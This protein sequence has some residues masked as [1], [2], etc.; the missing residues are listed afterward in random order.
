MPPPLPPLPPPPPPPPHPTPHS[1]SNIYKE[2]TSIRKPTARSC[3]ET[4]LKLEHAVALQRYAA[5]LLASLWSGCNVSHPGRALLVIQWMSASARTKFQSRVGKENMRA[6]E[7][8]CR[9]TSTAEFRLQRCVNRLKTT[10]KMENNNNF[11]K[12][13][14]IN[15]SQNSPNDS[16]RQLARWHLW[17]D[18]TLVRDLSAVRRCEAARPGPERPKQKPWRKRP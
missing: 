6:N 4:G 15:T 10:A 14:P 16:Q 7:H 2:Q 3:W 5:L 13:R 11:K 12:N 17:C 8:P 9:R 18:R 1:R